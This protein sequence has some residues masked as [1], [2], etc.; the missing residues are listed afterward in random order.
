M[1]H[2]ALAALRAELADLTLYDDAPSLRMH[3]RDFFWFSPVLKPDLEGKQA[4]L[5]VLPR[6]KAELRRVAS[7]CARHRVPVTVRGGGTGNYGQAVPLEGGVVLNMTRL[8][9]IVS[10]RL[11]A[12]RFEAGA[13]MLDIDKAVAP[14]G[15]ELRMHPS[16]RAQAT[17]GGFVAGG[18]AGAGSCTWG[19]IDNLGA[20]I[21]VEVMT[22]E[23]E[24]R[25]IELRGP[26][27]LKVMHAYGVNGIITEVEVPLAPA[28]DWAERIAIFDTLQ[29][30]A[31]FGQ[32]FTE[33]DGIAKKL[34][35]IHDPRIAPYL[36]RLAPWLGENKAFAILMV[37]EPQ[38]DELDRLVAQMG[39]TVT[40][41]RGAAEAR[42]AA[43]GEHREKGAPGPLYEY[44]W[45][46]TTL[47][48]LK[49]DPSITYLQLRFPPLRNLELLAWAERHFHEDV[50]FHIE[51]QRRQGKVYHSSLPL[52]RFTT[53]ERLHEIMA[54]A[55]AAGIQVS[56]PHSWV[57]NNAGWKQIDAPQPEFKRLAD[58]LGLMNPGKLLGWEASLDAAAE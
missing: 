37:S 35:S 53:A 23:P 26:D 52:V 27:I 24:P 20:V 56:N 42:A 4:E 9:R 15:Q 22:V 12:G 51:F 18:A 2:P 58:P 40:F 1:T 34:V 29:K 30:A 3:S 36:R 32:A 16:T 48:A 13:N 5:V 55:D 50:L 45:N 43:F 44:T 39:G 7:A 6:D 11:G 33:C 21:A 49:V 8:N 28:H 57:L 25:L 31:E 38:G 47:H 41:A 10:T 19:Q 46:H 14:L 54:Q 17:I